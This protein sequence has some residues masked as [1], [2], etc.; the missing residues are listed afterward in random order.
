MKVLMRGE[1]EGWREWK[2]GRKTDEA[3]WV[4]FGNCLKNTATSG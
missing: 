1:E 3:K 4:A 2:D